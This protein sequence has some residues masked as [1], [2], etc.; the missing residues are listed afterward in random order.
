MNNVLDKA[1]SHFREKLDKELHSFH[2]DEWQIDVFFKETTSFKNESKILNLQQEGK[3]VEALVES[4]VVKALTE[5]GKRMFKPADRVTLLNEVDP[6]VL[7][8]IASAINGVEE[9]F[10]EVEKN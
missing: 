4:I 8:K 7:I 3:A 9:T 10:E 6:A 1:I 5:D 2:V